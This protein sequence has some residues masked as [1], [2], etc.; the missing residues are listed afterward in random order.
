MT[1]K[2]AAV[3]RITV[4]CRVVE[5]R[6]VHRGVQRARRKAPAGACQRHGLRPVRGAHTRQ[7]GGLGLLQCQHGTTSGIR[8]AIL[9]SPG[10]W[11]KTASWS[12]R[13]HRGYHGPRHEPYEFYHREAELRARCGTI[14]RS[15]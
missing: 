8:M 2:I 13:V 15:R 9:T 1:G 5:C 10:E 12:E 7:D 3:E 14:K 4:H 11:R 6:I